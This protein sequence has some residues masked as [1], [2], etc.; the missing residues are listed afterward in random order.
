MT[1]REKQQIISEIA[2]KSGSLDD[3][4]LQLVYLF[5]GV[6]LHRNSENFQEEFYLF[7]K[8]AVLQNSSKESHRNR[9]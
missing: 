6:L 2:A 1:M 5:W 7:S 3:D 9:S 8:K 4:Q